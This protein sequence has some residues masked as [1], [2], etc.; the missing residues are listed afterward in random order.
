MAD[1]DEEIVKISHRKDNNKNK[2]SNKNGKKKKPTISNNALQGASGG[3]AWEDEIKR[4]WDLVTID[5]D[6]DNDMSLLISK[7]IESRKK[8]NLKKNFIKPFQRGIIRTLLLIL[9]N[10]ESML[11][12]DLRPNRYLMSLQYSIDFIHEFFDQNPISQLGIIIMRN[13]LAYLVS[14]I[15][16]NPQDHID[17]LKSMRKQESKGN[18][19]LQNAL[20]MARGLLLPVP[21]HCTREILIIFGGLSS[22]DPGDIHQTISSLVEE[23]IRVTV[24]GLSAQV[25]ICKKICKETNY[26]DENSYH[27]ILN[28]V[29]FK[30]L[31]DQ[32]VI[33]LPVNKINK[34]FTL[35]KMGFPT[36]IFEDNP[37]FCSCHNKLIYGGY[38]CPNC[39]CKICSLPMICPCCNLM[40]ILSTHLARSYHHLLPIKIYKEVDENENFPSE[41]CFSCQKVFPNLQN[42]K[43]GEILTSSRYRCPDC[44]KDFCIDCDVFIH[45]ILHNCPGCESK[46]TITL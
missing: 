43:T 46:P 20:E 37:T 16:G 12:K 28:E 17:I 23:K 31:L 40:L 18:P 9:D 7:I 39:N 22:T 26:N 42:K 24:I 6:N 35:V 3:Y 19:S 32:S 38:F 25:E 13:G 44:N 11:E 30:E 29:H 36:R 34:N 5:D 4:S 2:N 15:S 14:P 1:S 33:P 10:T 27:V 41:N 45:E 8:R 21:A